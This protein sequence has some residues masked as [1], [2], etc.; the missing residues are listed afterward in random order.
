MPTQNI[1]SQ[2]DRH[3]MAH[4]KETGQILSQVRPEDVKEL[5]DAI[6]TTPEH[7]A[8][9]KSLAAMSL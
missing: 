3:V 1:G 4:F 8:L 7:T 5:L 2:L 9:R 6:P